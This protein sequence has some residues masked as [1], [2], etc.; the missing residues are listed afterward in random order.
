[1]QQ[2]K[3]NGSE[4]RGTYIKCDEKV[5]IKIGKYSSENGIHAAARNFSLELGRN[6]NSSTIHGFKKVY[7]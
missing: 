7:L 1:M 6:I 4:K 2:A 5:K 3:I